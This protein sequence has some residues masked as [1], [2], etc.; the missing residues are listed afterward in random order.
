MVSRNTTCGRADGPARAIG[1]IAPPPGDTIEEEE[2]DEVEEVWDKGDPNAAAAAK[3]GGEVNVVAEGL[4]R[5]DNGEDDRPLVVVVV[6]PFAS[7]S[8]L[9]TTCS[10]DTR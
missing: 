3:S 8:P 4:L 9:P 7:T 5:H 6:L 10:G 1:G 2:K